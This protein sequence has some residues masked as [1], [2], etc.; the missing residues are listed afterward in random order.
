MNFVKLRNWR[1][2][3]AIL[4]S[5]LLVLGG[6]AHAQTTTGSISGTAVDD[7]NL[8]LPGVS[9]TLLEE[10]TGA[11]RETVT[12]AAGAF[13]F[14]S[15]QPG[16]YT[17]R[18]ELQGFGTYEQINT[19]LN[20]NQQLSLGQVQLGIAQLEETVQVIATEQRVVETI[21]SDRSALITEE[22]I[23]TITVRGRDVTSML[24]VL[25]GV[26]YEKDTE[27]TGEIVIGSW[28]PEVSG[29]RAQWS[30]VTIDGVPSND[31]GLPSVSTHSM[32]ADAI[33]EVNVQLNNF[34]ADS[35]RNGGANINIITKSGSNDFSGGAYAYGRHERFRKQNHFDMLNG[36][37]KPLYRYA[38][39]GGNVGGRFVRDKFFFFYNY[40]NWAVETPLSARQ[41]TVPSALERA[42]DF[43]QSLD[44]GGNLMV[45]TDPTTGLPFPGNKI[46]ADRINPNGVALLDHFPMPNVGR[47]ASGGNYNYQFGRTQNAPRLN[48][49]VRFDYRPTQNDSVYS[50]YSHWH[51]PSTSIQGGVGVDHSFTYDDYAFAENYTRV[52]G[53]NAVNEFSFGYRH[54][55]EWNPWADSFDITNIQRA[56]AGYTMGQFNAA[57]NPFGLIPEMSFGGMIP[58]G[59]GLS[60]DSRFINFGNDDIF[61]VNN[62]FSVTAGRHSIK[63]GFYYENLTNIEG[64][65]ASSFAGTY[66]FSQDPFNPGETNHPY[67]NAL[68]GSFKSY[69]ENSAR[70]GQRA[71]HQIFN[72]FIQDKW[73]PTNK[74]TMD[75]G[76]R[77]STYTYYNQ[78]AG[79]LGDGTMSGGESASFMGAEF[80]TSKIPSLYQP[81]MHN[82]VR[83][84]L[85]PVTGAVGPALLIGAM[86]EGSGDFANGMVHDVDP[87]Y[88]ENFMDPVGILIEP[89]VGI[90]YD[91]AGDG[92]TAIR[93]NF[94]I[95]HNATQAGA[96]SWR[97]ALNPPHVYTP[98]IYY[99]NMST[100]LQQTG[101]RFPSH[102]VYSVVQGN[103]PPEMINFQIGIQHELGLGTVLDAAFVATRGKNLPQ[104]R[105]INTIPQG[106]RFLAANQDPTRPGN[107]LP[108]NFFR[109]Y[110][111]YGDIMQVINNGP[112]EYN[113]L[114][115]AINRRYTGGLEFTAAYTYSQAKDY[116]SADILYGNRSFIPYY[117]NLNTYAWGLADF[118][119]P[120]NLVLSYNWDIPDPSGTVARAIF[121]GWNL[122]GI[123][124]FASGTPVGVGFSTTDGADILGGGDQ[125]RRMLRIDGIGSVNMTD[126][127]VVSGDPNSGPRT[128]DKWFNTSAFGRP[129]IGEVGNARKDDV[130]MPGVSDTGIRLSKQMPF[131][132]G[133][134]S[135][136]LGMEVYNLFSEVSYL[137]VDTTAQFDAAGKQVDD[138]FGAV[139]ASRTPFTMLFNMRY[140]F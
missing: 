117:R 102:P 16:V 92:R 54:S 42:G 118:D 89:R 107:A 33:G 64:R 70:L 87:R 59:A 103:R 99:G 60:Y 1:F 124:T 106:A 97:Q 95:F 51:Q 100:L 90:A 82:G 32:S 134:Q 139:I 129:A 49:V 78:E 12:N 10:T 133:G 67:A 6:V 26:S 19:N 80:D 104:M 34:T 128:I 108:D 116:T 125:M 44:T 75:I 140:R 20:V 29:A 127:A 45:V 109:P 83:S 39:Y 114:Q 85:N 138:R 131:G 110:M 96:L 112:S 120:H 37:D 23:E 65:G 41:N 79:R 72:A 43:S 58:N 30:T 61:T 105:N 123:S 126:R 88:P 121:G 111:G 8:A 93:A 98:T 22:Q 91:V 71:S 50:R 17:V 35:G 27:A 18:L 73:Q 2:T 74:L 66:D 76:V 31:I 86:V 47:E 52:I 7:T 13:N 21:T 94:G 25:P 57:I 69:S 14:A 62:A 24:R 135:L 77:F 55:R 38:T 4:A 115:V 36:I 136:E 46:P 84:S 132:V 101:V 40:E 3:C 122:S 81:V 53:N 9:A 113:A 5:A 137:E 63:T 11:L 56:T 15:V 48:N 68:I 28:L 130:R 119:R